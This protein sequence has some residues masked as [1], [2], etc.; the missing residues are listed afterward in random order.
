MKLRAP[1]GY[2]GVI[3]DS[4]QLGYTAVDGIVEIPD[5]KIHDGLWAAGFSVAVIAPKVSSPLVVTPFD[6]E[7]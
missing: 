7:A 5:D 1:E 4:D 3:R 2:T 6:G